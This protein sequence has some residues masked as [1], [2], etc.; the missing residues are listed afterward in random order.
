[1]DSFSDKS[2]SGVLVPPR[3]VMYGNMVCP[4]E[5]SRDGDD[6]SPSVT[7]V[8]SCDHSVTQLAP[9]L[10]RTSDQVLSQDQTIKHHAEHFAPAASEQRL[11]IRPGQ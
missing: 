4:V 8:L 3:P 11:A 6:S 10:S 1:M 7:P 5:T 2:D 9:P